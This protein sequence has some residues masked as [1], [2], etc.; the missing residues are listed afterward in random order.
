M[1]L[2]QF[3][4][5]LNP[6]C[7]SIYHILE[8]WC[9]STN[10]LYN[11]INIYY[12]LLC[13]NVQLFNAIQCFICNDTH[14]IPILSR[15]TCTLGFG[16]LQLMSPSICQLPSA[17]SDFERGV[18]GG[19]KGYIYSKSDNKSHLI[20]HI[21]RKNSGNLTLFIWVTRGSGS[22]YKPGQQSHICYLGFHT[23][24]I[25]CQDNK[26][27]NRPILVVNRT[28]LGSRALRGGVIL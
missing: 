22:V 18:N 1:H 12:L 5:L 10:Q 3:P 2:Y 23:Q 28:N 9:I 25:F 4:W 8:L 15:C 21:W 20:Q 14:L 16:V 27:S 19:H 24:L 26:I 11:L 7:S 13:I 6:K 17:L